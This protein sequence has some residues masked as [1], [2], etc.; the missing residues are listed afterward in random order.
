MAKKHLK[1]GIFITLEGPEASGK[2]TQ[3]RL[4]RR[5]LESRGWRVTLTREPGGVPLAESVRKIFLDRA[6]RLS[7]WAELFLVN[8]ARAEHVAH[9]I[10]PA[11]AQGRAVLCD[12]FTDSTEAYQGH[13]R[14]LPLADVR[15][16]NRLA[17]GGLKPQL[18]LL[19]DTPP[20]RGLARAKARQAPDR[21]ESQAVAF[22]KKVRAGFLSLARREPRRVRLI[23]WRE[24]PEEVHREVADIVGHFLRRWS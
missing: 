11:L 1:T 16:V 23:P 21:M 18:T 22:H 7:P 8:A 17:A 5:F 15:A 10:R 24:G 3:A 6:F 4:L 9:V 14:G 13:G 2:S 19:L 20:R 12:R